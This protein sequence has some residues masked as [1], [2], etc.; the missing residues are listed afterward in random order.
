MD[1]LYDIRESG[2]YQCFMRKVFADVNL[3]ENGYESLNKDFKREIKYAAGNLM[4]LQAR[5][6]VD[7]SLQVLVEFF[8][9]F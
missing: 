8:E 7:R 6:I 3:R 1:D 5:Q 4:H 9:G 2:S